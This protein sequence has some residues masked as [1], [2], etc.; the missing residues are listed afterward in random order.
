M[1]RHEV[2]EHIFRLLFM[3]EFHEGE[4]LKEQAKIVND[5]ANGFYAL[6]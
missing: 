6:G 3:V 4:E 1:T 2:R 5:P